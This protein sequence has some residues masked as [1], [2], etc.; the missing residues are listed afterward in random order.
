MHVILHWLLS[1]LSLM[2][3]AHIVPGFMVRSFPSALLAA[4]VIGLVNATIGSCSRS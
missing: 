4:V 3:V 2:I 1:A